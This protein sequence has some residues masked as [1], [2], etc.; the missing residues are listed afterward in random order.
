MIIGQEIMYKGQPHIVWGRSLT[1]N[2]I[3]LY[4]DGKLINMS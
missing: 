4:K 1:N 2:R 3:I